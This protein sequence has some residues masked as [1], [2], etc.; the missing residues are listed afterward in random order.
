MYSVE[1]SREAQLFYAQSDKTITK[2]LDRCFESLEKNPRAGNNVK[3]L[4]G[5]L[6]GSY[7]YR[8]GDLRV[9]YTINDQE[10]IVLV[11]TIAKRSN[12]YD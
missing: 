9:V 1:L 2:K 5:P 10:L 7:R 4:K 3:A 12:V 11:I 8:V 6:A